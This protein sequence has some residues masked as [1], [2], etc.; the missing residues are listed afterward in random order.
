MSEVFAKKTFVALLNPHGTVERVFPGV[1]NNS[2]DK[3][4]IY[5]GVKKTNVIRAEF[6]RKLEGCSAYIH[7]IDR[8]S[9][10]GRAV[11]QHLINPL[12]LRPM[13]GSS[14]G[15]ALNVFY[16][17][18]DL[19]VG[20]D[21]GGSVLAPAA[22][23]NLYSF[24]APSID[25]DYLKGFEKTST[26]GISFTPSIGFIARNLET[27][28]RPLSLFFRRRSVERRLLALPD[29][30]DIYGERRPLIE[31]LRKNVGSGTLLISRE[32]PVDRNGIGDSIFG[33][34]D[35]STKESQ[36][37]SGKGLMRVVNMAGLAAATI[38]TRELG[39]C[40]LLISSDDDE[41]YSAILD[42]AERLAV[43]PNELAERYF[44]NLDNYF[45]SYQ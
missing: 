1:I 31:F 18:N 12:T 20:S 39:V 43:P 6:T 22:A 19:G 16:H 41:G 26:D 35:E 42:E 30:L 14:S 29:G 36:R 11:D 15:T 5:L 7:T 27:L 2:S 44:G 34:Y 4:C 24:I 8:M 3:D 28:K 10:G 38:P 40:N 23:L 17:I 45:D 32:G 21:G 33:Q 13:T 9:Q 37:L 25:G